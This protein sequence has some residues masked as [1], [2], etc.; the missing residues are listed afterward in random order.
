MRTVVGLNTFESVRQEMLQYTGFMVD[1]VHCC[2]LEL[3]SAAVEAALKTVAH[4]TVSS[5]LQ[6]ALLMAGLIWFLMFL[7]LQYDFT[8][9]NSSAS[10]PQIGTYIQSTKICMVNLQF[11]H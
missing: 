11:V 3:A 4:L 9:E 1:V 8:A 7:P 6:D 10:V 2:E 5:K